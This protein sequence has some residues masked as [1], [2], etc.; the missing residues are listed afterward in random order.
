MIKLQAKG[1]QGEVAGWLWD[2]LI[3]RTQRV[4]VGDKLSSEQEVESG[5]PQGTVMGQCLFEVYIDDIDDMADL[6]DLL[7][8]FAD[9]CKG[10]NPVLN[11]DDRANLQE[12][13]NKLYNWAKEW[14][15][16]Q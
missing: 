14:G 6:I 4:C 12:E 5:V 1:I 8:K 2:W 15:V 3:G 11:D 16:F 7:S 9:D 10:Q 13:I